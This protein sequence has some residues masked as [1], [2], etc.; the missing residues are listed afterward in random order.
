[1]IEL[2]LTVTGRNWYELERAAELAAERFMDG[3]VDMRIVSMTSTAEDHVK[4]ATGGVIS[5]RAEY[6]VLLEEVS[7]SS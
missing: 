5:F 4:L 6:T 1:V 3:P 2:R 7:P